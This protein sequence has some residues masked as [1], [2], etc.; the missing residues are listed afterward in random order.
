MIFLLLSQST[1]C[2]LHNE[3]WLQSVVCIGEGWAGRWTSAS[4]RSLY[5]IMQKMVLTGKYGW[6]G[7]F[8]WIQSRGFIGLGSGLSQFSA[9]FSISCLR[10]T[11]YQTVVRPSPC[12]IF[13]LVSLCLSFIV[14]SIRLSVFRKTLRITIERKKSQKW[15]NPGVS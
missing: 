12:F 2:H 10:G 14:H 13:P 8:G 11:L 4:A 1:R 7:G 15:V 5:A 3:C 9:T 6:V